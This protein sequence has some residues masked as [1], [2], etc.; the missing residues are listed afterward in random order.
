MK[1]SKMGKRS[2][3]FSMVLFLAACGEPSQQESNANH[4]SRAAAYQDQ[5][6]YKAATIEYKNAVKKSS[7]E[8]SAIVPYAVMLNKLGQ[9]SA[10]LSTLEQV[11]AGKN[12]AYFIAQIDAYQGMQKYLSAE[13]VIK[14]NL[15]GDSVKA[16]LLKARNLLGLNELDKAAAAYQAILAEDATNDDARLGKAMALVRS[17]DF[18]EGRKLLK[19]IG[20]N[21][22]AYVKA[23]ILLAGVFIN[24]Q[25]LEQ[26]EAT[27]S[28]LLSEMRNTDII[29]PEKAVVLERLSY[30]LTRQGRSNEAYI[31]TKLLSEAFPGSNKVKEQYEL[32]VEKLRAGELS[33]AKAVLIKIL[34]EYPSYKQA[35]QLLGVISYIEGDNSSAS[36]Y[37]SESVDP[38]VANEMTRHI[39]AATN[40]K[41]ND[42]KKV[43]EILEP[44]IERTTTSATLAL[45][46]LAAIS[47][48]Q[49]DKGEKALLKA[50]SIDQGNNRIRLA[51]SDL[52]R[53]GAKEDSKKEWQQLEAAYKADATDL[54]V[55]R[56]IV[57]FHLRN[58]GTEKA[59]GFIDEALAS[60]EKDYSTN[61]VAGYFALNQNNM[62][63]ALAHFSVAAEVEREGE[64]YL[65]ALF[66]KGKAEISLKQN[67]P[68]KKTFNEIIRV[69]PES[70]LGYKG[71]LSVYLIEDNASEGR[72][73]LEAY[74]LRNAQLAP[75]YV[76]IQ[77]AISQQNVVSAKD[78]YEKARS[79]N[80]DD[81][82]VL[83]LGNGIKYVEALLAMKEGDFDNA[84]KMVAEVLSSEPDNMRLLS[85]LVD[86]E[87]R[88]GK[89]NE[90]E[91][92]LGQ[93]EV[94][95]ATHPV[96]DL[97]KGDVAFAKKDYVQAKSR[98]SKG[99][100][101]TPS[102]ATADKLYRVL[103][104]LGETKA[105]N[106][107]LNTWLEKSPNS[108][109]ALMYQSLTYQQR[110]QRIKAAEGY[111][112]VLSITPNNPMALNNL[113]WIYFEKKDARA[114][115][116]LKKA[117]ELA[118]NSAAVLDS[119]GWV[120]AQNG[121]PAEGLPYLEKA[122]ELAPQIKEI[123][124][125]LKAV[126]AMQ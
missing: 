3:A 66:A 52:Y 93:I 18:S 75:Y 98:Y 120:L 1:F 28:T 43:L 112:K 47:D 62:K 61:L 122:Y 32:A 87:L 25:D 80:S 102:D 70:E 74:A 79:S 34:D 46:G 71:L 51:L 67:A 29:E 9:Y 11:T 5:G 16:K 27:L 64:N 84:R 15:Q 35:T 108:P 105:Q 39:Y 7:G 59:Q 12:E 125:H 55:L 106:A 107:H 126:K 100:A 44:N 85:F 56:G 111:E 97:L 8:A 110:G 72:D 17:N 49:Y 22:D 41:L 121:K 20:K 118:P 26:A 77:E 60:A 81:E 13:K 57:S 103:G 69:F 33:G 78:Y 89:V 101:R 14:E 90:A 68:A 83:R 104:M 58:G 23:N 88:A 37:L 4:L 94:Q 82:R 48:K 124:E 99:W 54:Q 91:K 6:Q 96:I 73:K 65:N 113:G 36:K 31:Y 42:P 123:G 63:K 21:S 95:D 38:E 92:V 119:Y 50:L 10:S 76:L 53:T 24:E 117:A 116:L 40:L 109:A 45:Y 114:L 19:E 2:I 30:V 86:L 115:E